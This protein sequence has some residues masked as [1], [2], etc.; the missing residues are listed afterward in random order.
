MGFSV[1]FKELVSLAIRGGGENTV[2]FPNDLNRS[3]VI[4]S[5]ADP[6]SLRNRL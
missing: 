2:V 3:I 6:A 4:T 5:D 1:T